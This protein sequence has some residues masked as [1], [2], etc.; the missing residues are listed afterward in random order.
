MDSTRTSLF[1]QRAAT[2]LFR[3]TRSSRNGVDVAIV[4]I[5]PRRDWRSVKQ[6]AI[7]KGSRVKT[8]RR[9]ST[10]FAG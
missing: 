9:E 3:V 4:I 1:A 2:R 5:A 8:A 10:P 6:K 7:G